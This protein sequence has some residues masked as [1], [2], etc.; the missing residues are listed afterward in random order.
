MLCLISVC[1]TLSRAVSHVYPY[2]KNELWGLCTPDR[3]PVTE[4]LYSEISSKGAF[5]LGQ[6][7]GKPLYDVYAINGKLLQ[8]AVNPKCSMFD[9]VLVTLSQPGIDLKKQDSGKVSILFASGRTRHYDCYFVE[10]YK[11]DYNNDLHVFVVAEPGGLLDLLD[12]LNDKVLLP[13]KYN[14]LNAIRNDKQVDLFL[15]WNSRSDYKV[16]AHPEKQLRRFGRTFL[17][18]AK[19]MYRENEKFLGVVNRN[20]ELYD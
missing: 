17:E 8:S 20:G 16:F 2:S 11:P 6:L 13:L 12:I 14:E 3:K 10:S 15:G 1:S 18:D 7:P 9:T 19:S 5:V 4:A